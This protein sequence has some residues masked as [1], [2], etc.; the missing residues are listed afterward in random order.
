MDRFKD[1]TGRTGPATWE[2]G[3]YPMDR[4]YPVPG[5]SWYEAAAFAEFAGKS[6][7]TIY[8]WYTAAGMGVEYLYRSAQQPGRRGAGGCR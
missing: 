5:V 8:H 6:L 1:P 2:A 4:R 7:P 3:T